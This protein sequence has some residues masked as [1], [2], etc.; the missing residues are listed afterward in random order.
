MESYG[1]GTPVDGSSSSSSKSGNLSSACDLSFRTSAHVFAKFFGRCQEK[2]EQLPVHVVYLTAWNQPAGRLGWAMADPKKVEAKAAALTDLKRLEPREGTEAIIWQ[3]AVEEDCRS[4]TSLLDINLP[5]NSD[6]QVVQH[7][8]ARDRLF[9]LSEACVSNSL[10]DKKE[11]KGEKKQAAGK[12]EDGRRGAEIEQEEQS[13]QKVLEELQL[14][15]CGRLGPGADADPDSSGQQCLELAR[16]LD[17][18]GFE[19]R[20]VNRVKKGIL[21]PAAAAAGSASASAASKRS[22]KS[23]KSS[24]GAAA[25][26]GDGHCDSEPRK[27]L[28]TH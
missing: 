14:V 5:F 20:R 26:G 22:K 10:S 15:E 21:Q 18:D 4:L 6:E 8:S 19:S 3:K 27:R 7:V 13:A 12:I 25:S 11:G 17:E 24:S 23:S 28:H 16:E 1:S 9:D 2:G